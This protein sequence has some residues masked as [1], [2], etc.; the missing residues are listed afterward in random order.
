MAQTKNATDDFLG[1]MK[2]ILAIHKKMLP[3]LKDFN[4]AQEK[5]LVNQKEMIELMQKTKPLVDTTK[6]IKEQANA[7]DSVAKSSKKA[8]KETKETQSWLGKLIGDNKSGLLRNQ[9]GGVGFI[10]RMMYGVSGYFILKNRVDGILSGVDKYIVRPLSGLKGEDGKQ[11][12]LGKMFFGIGGSY[13]KTQEQ[14]KSI[15]GVAT[16]VMSSVAAA[17]VETALYA[18]TE[19]GVNVG[20]NMDM[21]GF[22]RTGKDDGI[23]TR[24]AKKVTEKV[25]SITGFNMAQKFHKKVVKFLKEDDK[26]KKVMDKLKKFKDKLKE[27]GAA[28]INKLKT[29]LFVAVTLFVIVL[30]VVVV[31][32]I[33]LVVI[34]LIVKLLKAGGMTAEKGMDI[35]KTFKS[36]VIK[37]ATDLYVGLT[38]MKSGF[39][40]IWDAVFGG[41]SLTDLFDSFLVVM[42]GIFATVSALL[43]LLIMPLLNAAKEILVVMADGLREEIRTFLEKAGAQLEFISIILKIIG[44]IG[45]A[46]GVVMIILGGPIVTAIGAVVAVVAGIGL[47]IGMLIDWINPFAEGGVTKQGMSLVGEKG[48]ELVRLPTGSRVHSNQESKQ[49]M[50]GGVSGNTNNITVNVQGRI[51]ASDSELRLIAQKVGQMINKEINRTTSSRGLGA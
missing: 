32:F 39:M 33:V 35:M 6:A 20:K 1:S 15:S 28:I 4:K 24:G 14:I 38:T 10:H 5:S 25:K 47:V 22:A 43:L 17:A 41:G 2:G 8:T 7:Y 36:D 23:V 13:R 34:F 9:T 11:G 3:A 49:M 16:G 27:K 19:G 40:G 21:G 29:Y 42:E 44:V 31:A 26:R 18:V 46:I 12:I 51:G 48:P 30:K 37:Y 50:S 45:L